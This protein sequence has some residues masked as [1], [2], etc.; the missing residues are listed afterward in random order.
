MA[1][2]GLLGAAATAAVV[3]AVAAG[4]VNLFGV[5]FTIGV[6]ASIASW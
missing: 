3:A 5:G 1:G 4:T 2:A 6:L